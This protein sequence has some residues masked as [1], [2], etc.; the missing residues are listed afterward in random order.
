MKHGQRKNAARS[1]EVLERWNRG[2]TSNGIA[3]A[4]GIS[5]GIVAGIIDRAG[6]RAEKR[7]SPHKATRQA[8]RPSLI[9]L[10]PSEG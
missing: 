8:A 2:E 10:L 7:P 5:R 4:M 6:D 9:P 1:Q 3:A